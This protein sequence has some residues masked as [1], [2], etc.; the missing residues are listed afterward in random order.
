MPPAKSR[1]AVAAMLKTIF[2]RETRAEAEA[3]WA[4]VADALREKQ[5]RLAAMRDASR[6]DMLVSMDAP[7]E[8]WTQIASTTPLGRMNREIKRP[9]DVIGIFPNDGAL[10]RLV[11]AFA[12]GLEPMAI[13]W[14]TAGNQRGRGG[15]TTIHEP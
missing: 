7:R 11:G 4:V 2:A 13:T 3:Q 6:D 8:H 5:P 12:T 9:A 10:I 15:R 1:A 14:L